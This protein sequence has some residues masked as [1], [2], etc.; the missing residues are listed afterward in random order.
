MTV[1]ISFRNVIHTAEETGNIV[2]AT[3]DVPAHLWLRLTHVPPRIH[4][5]PVLRRGMWLNDDVRFCFD[6]FHDIEQDQ[7]GD[8]LEHTFTISPCESDFQF[9]YYLWGYVGGILSPSTSAILEYKTG[10]TCP[11]IH[12]IMVDALLFNRT[13]GDKHVVWPTI[14]DSP[15]EPITPTHDPPWTRLVAE[16]RL[17]VSYFIYRCWIRFDTTIIPVGS[18]IVDAW[19]ILYCQIVNKTSSAVYPHICATQGVQDT[20]IVPANYGDQ[21][22][23][24]T[25]GGQVSLDDCIE[26][27]V[28]TI[29]LNTT[30]KTWVIPAGYSLFCIRQEM[31]V[32]DTV[33]P[34]GANALA[35]GSAQ[36]VY[37]QRPKLVVRYEPPPPP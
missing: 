5:K 2:T 21:L 37:W 36:S 1:H 23:V 33:P 16:A 9:W 18:T 27:E 31:D 7:A 32:L 6:V 8:T 19:L 13:A 24:T 30:G 15:A 3:S 4:S 14:H 29:L 11:A 20:P 17:T 35:F 25:I 22:A 10:L 12:Q 28:T 34:A 26:G